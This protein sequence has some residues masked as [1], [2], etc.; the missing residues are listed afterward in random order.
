M[1]LKITFCTTLIIQKAF[2]FQYILSTIKIPQTNQLNE[3]EKTLI[4]FTNQLKLH[5]TASP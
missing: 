2:V 5:I 1:T 4:T 3:K